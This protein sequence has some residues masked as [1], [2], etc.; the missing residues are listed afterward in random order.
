MKQKNLL[1]NAP[2]HSLIILKA[3]SI[4]FKCKQVVTVLSHLAS[5]SY[6]RS[7]IKYIHDN[8]MQIVSASRTKTLP[9]AAV[10]TSHS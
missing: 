7:H 9:R 4:V 3:I 6:G 1:M 8:C 5:T 2:G 10:P